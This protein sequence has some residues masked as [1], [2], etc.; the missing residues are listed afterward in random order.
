MTTHIAGIDHVQLAAP[1][2]CEAVVRAFFGDML[3]M[4]ELT[5]PEKLQARGGVWFQC[6]AQQLHIGVEQDF[7]PAKKAHPAFLVRDLTR[8]CET[9]ARAG[10]PAVEDPLPGI[11]R[12][13]VFDPF[14]NRL[15][16]VELEE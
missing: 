4:V 12:C 2:N 14:G 9:L 10:Y 8:L 13:F 16:F 11:R 3:G 7:V 6:G 1:P 5:K 15:E